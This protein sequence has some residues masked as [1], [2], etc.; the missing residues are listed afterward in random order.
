M[1]I[2]DRGYGMTALIYGLLAG[3]VILFM[4]LGCHEPAADASVE[5]PR[6]LNTLKDMLTNPKFWIYGLTNAFY[7]AAMALVLS[8]IHI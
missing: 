5:K 1:C 7:S 3:A 8:L 6:L 4:A 2:R